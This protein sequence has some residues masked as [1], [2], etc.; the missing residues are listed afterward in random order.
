MVATQP[1]YFLY[2]DPEVK[3][4]T[5][6]IMLGERDGSHWLLGAEESWGEAYAGVY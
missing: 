1:N 3:S 6:E 2:S 4:F 5:G